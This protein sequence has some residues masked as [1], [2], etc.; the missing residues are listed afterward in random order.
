[1]TPLM[2]DPR[3]RTRSESGKGIG[4]APEDRRDDT[5]RFVT[6]AL[7]GSRF[8]LDSSQVKEVVMP[9]RVYAFPHT[10]PSLEGVL[11]RRGTAIPVCDP[12]G[13]FGEGGPRSLYLIAQCSYAGAAHV[14]AFPVSG[15]CELVQ[16][17]PCEST[18]ELPAGGIT[19][20]ITFVSGLLRT[21]GG[22]LPLLDMDRVVAHCME[23]PLFAGR[24]ARQ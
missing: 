7:G 15:A 3:S 24:E 5:R 4:L 12:A 20:G 6:F 23:L 8:A 1:M 2:G 22:M 18:E 21:A 17:E 11:V 14:V 9:S 19:G 16:G 10:T 13:A